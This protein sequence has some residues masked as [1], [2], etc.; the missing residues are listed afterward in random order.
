M[1]FNINKNK[2]VMGWCRF[3]AIARSSSTAYDVL[4]DR[5]STTAAGLLVSQLVENV[6]RRRKGTV[7]GADTMG[8]ICVPSETNPRLVGVASL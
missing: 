3:F 2:V 7:V 6:L 4:G 8:H 5:R 1:I